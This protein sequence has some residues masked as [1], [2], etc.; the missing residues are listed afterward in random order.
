MRLSVW[1]IP[2]WLGVL[3]TGF[4]VRQRRDVAVV[5]NP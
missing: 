3:W 5:G 4:L 2:V 1:L